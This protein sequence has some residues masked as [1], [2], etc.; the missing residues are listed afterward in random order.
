MQ[1]RVFSCFVSHEHAH[2]KMDD[3]DVQ[4]VYPLQYT[5]R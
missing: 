1:Q 3:F 4:L 2:Q 5:L